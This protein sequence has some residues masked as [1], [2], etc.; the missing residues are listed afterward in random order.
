MVS[1]VVCRQLAQEEYDVRRKRRF[2]AKG[3]PKDLQVYAVR[4][5]D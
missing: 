1:E 2:R 3:A 4:L 5:R